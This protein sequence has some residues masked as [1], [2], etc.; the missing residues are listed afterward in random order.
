MTR[1]FSVTAVGLWLA[2]AQHDIGIEV[3][4]SGGMALFWQNPKRSAPAPTPKTL[5]PLAIALL[6][7]LQA[8][9]EADTKTRT[10][11]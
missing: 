8:E 10:A 11:A 1:R 5:S 9:V 7:K 3:A 2:A 6:L 4:V